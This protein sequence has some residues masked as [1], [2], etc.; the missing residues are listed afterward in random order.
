MQLDQFI[1]TTL[2]NI[3]KGIEAANKASKHVFWITTDS[4]SSSSFVEFDVAVT[5]TDEKKGKA[6]INVW[7]IGAGGSR[8]KKDQHLSRL[9][10]KILYRG[11]RKKSR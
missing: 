9:K 4:K 5:S 6:G 1:T 8:A 7:A 10:F 11:P 3:A 2:T